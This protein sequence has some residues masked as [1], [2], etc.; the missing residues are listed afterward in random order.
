MKYLIKIGYLRRLNNLIADAFSCFNLV[1]IVV[2]VL[3][4]IGRVVLFYVYFVVTANCLDARTDDIDYQ[5]ADMTIPRIAKLLNEN[6]LSDAN[7]F[8]VYSTLK[9]SFNVKN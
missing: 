4:D 3:V 2:Q 1:L 6:S 9:S 7:K 5:H 8:E